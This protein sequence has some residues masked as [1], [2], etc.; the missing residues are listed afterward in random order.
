MGFREEK[1]LLSLRYMFKRDNITEGN[2]QLAL[3]MITEQ[4]FLLT[5]NSLN[6]E[7]K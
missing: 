6:K 4:K 2:K 1:K 3:S 7:S 5:S